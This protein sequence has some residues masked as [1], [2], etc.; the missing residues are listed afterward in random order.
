MTRTFLPSDEAFWE[1]DE[2]LWASVTQYPPRKAKLPKVLDLG[3]KFI[4]GA[5]VLFVIVAAVWSAT[6]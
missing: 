1:G 2:R 3:L 4:G 6:P 5:T